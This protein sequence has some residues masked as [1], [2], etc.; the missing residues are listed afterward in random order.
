M[1][2]TCGHAISG[3]GCSAASETKYMATV[4]SRPVC[5]THLVVLQLCLQVHQLL[6]LLLPPLLLR[7]Q[8]RLLLLCIVACTSERHH[9]L[10]DFLPRLA[11]AHYSSKPLDCRQTRFLRCTKNLRVPEA[12]MSIATWAGCRGNDAASWLCAFFMIDSKFASTPCGT[13]NSICGQLHT[14]VLYRRRPR[15]AMGLVTSTAPG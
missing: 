6:L 8:L 12:C 3:A 5:C 10:A 15:S 11:D 9:D 2:R 4:D 14:N 1:L 7:L 13:S